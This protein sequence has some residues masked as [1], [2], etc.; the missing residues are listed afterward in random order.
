MQ[1]WALICSCITELLHFGFFKIQ[2]TKIVKT[3]KKQHNQGTTQRK[4]NYCKA[5]TF[6]VGK[7]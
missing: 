7:W 2:Y 4:I 3:F 5:R 6:A 1:R